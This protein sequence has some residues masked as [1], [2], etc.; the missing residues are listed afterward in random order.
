MHTEL[1][2]PG[3]AYVGQELRFLEPLYIGE[4][5]TVEVTVVGK[6]EAKHILIMDTMVRKQN[7]QAVLSG[8]SALKRLRFK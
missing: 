2:G 1:T 3:F 7:G 6:K 8:L 5:I 4:R